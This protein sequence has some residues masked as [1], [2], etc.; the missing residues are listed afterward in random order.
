MCR[1][2]ESVSRRDGTNNSRRDDTSTNHSTRVSVATTSRCGVA[3]RTVSRRD[4]V[5]KFWPAW[6]AIYAGVLKS[7]SDTNS[8]SSCSSELGNS[9]GR[10]EAINSPPMPSS[11]DV[12]PSQPPEAPDSWSNLKIPPAQWAWPA[13]GQSQPLYRRYQWNFTRLGFSVVVFS[14]AM[15]REFRVSFSVCF[16]LSSDWRRTLW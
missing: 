10:S 5:V 4:E 2:D 16:F 13:G 14:V 1:H 6:P 11:Q 9:D 8:P 7:S 3:T 15:L 12:G